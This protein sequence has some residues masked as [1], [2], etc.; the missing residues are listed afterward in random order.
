MPNPMDAIFEARD[1]LTLDEA[2]KIVAPYYAE[3]TR[4]IFSHGTPTGVF[5]VLGQEIR[6]HGPYAE[7]CGPV[8][9]RLDRLE[10]E[11]EADPRNIAARL[12]AEYAKQCEREDRGRDAVALA[13]RIAYE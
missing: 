7:C 9:D 5:N 6:Q 4:L 2:D 8:N 10:H 13:Q 1:R 3:R 11:F 12:M